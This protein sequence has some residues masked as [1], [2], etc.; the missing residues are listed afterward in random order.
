MSQMVFYT[1]PSCTSCRKTKAWLKQN[2][3]SYEERHIFKETPDI[4]ELMNI[5]K[6]TND[7]LK[8]ILATRSETF[9][10]LEVDINDLKVSE[11]L[12]LL[13]D[14]PKLLRRPILTDGENLIVGFNPNRLQMLNDQKR[15]SSK[16]VS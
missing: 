3:I 14:K 7:G 11:V 12:Q 6:L 10:S 2:Q 9:K 15:I 13:H 5:I 16:H 8:E 1:Y 4:D